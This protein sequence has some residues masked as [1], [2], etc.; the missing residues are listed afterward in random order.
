MKTFSERFKT[1]EQ[2]PLLNSRGIPVIESASLK[3][4][5]PIVQKPVNK[6]SQRERQKVSKLSDVFSGKGSDGLPKHDFLLFVTLGPLYYSNVERFKH[7]YIPRPTAKS[8]LKESVIKEK[9]VEF[10]KKVQEELGL[11]PKFKNI[12]TKD[13]TKIR[14]IYELC[15][16]ETTFFVSS[17]DFF[18]GCDAALKKYPEGM[19]KF[20][21]E[22]VLADSS[23]PSLSYRWS[24]RILQS[25]EKGSKRWRPTSARSTPRSRMTSLSS[26]T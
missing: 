11:N 5:L 6:M 1:N 14:N 21:T 15:E 18:I 22:V 17:M 3:K 13:G 9:L 25:N 26:P 8:L 7:T 2:K 12:F 16:G 19:S 10:T 24:T 4:L 20:L 23:S